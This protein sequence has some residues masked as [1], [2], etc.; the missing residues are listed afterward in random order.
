[1]NYSV[2]PIKINIH[3]VSER[4]PCVASEVNSQNTSTEGE[5]KVVIKYSD[6]VEDCLKLY[7]KDEKKGMA[8]MIQLAAKEQDKYAMIFV[9]SYYG[10][11]DRDMSR[12]IDMYKRV[13]EVFGE[14][15]AILS[16]L[17]NLYNVKGDLENAMEYYT[18]AISQGSPSAKLNIETLKEEMRE[19]EFNNK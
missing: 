6:E 17:G 19:Y 10:M 13:L 15:G 7:S 8:K 1:M 5:E 12:S 9:A 2:D 4:N 11:I 18:R 16:K 14:D 3:N